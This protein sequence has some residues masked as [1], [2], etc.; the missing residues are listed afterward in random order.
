VQLNTAV[1]DLNT[2]IHTAVAAS[3]REILEKVGTQMEKL[4]RQT[5]AA[6]DS[7]AKVQQPNPPATA[8]R[9]PRPAAAPL[10][11]SDADTDSRHPA[12][13][14]TYTVQKGDTI[15][16]IARKTGAK[17]QDIITANKLTDPS[18]IMVG[19]TLLIPGGK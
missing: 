7:L 10:V 14:A 11:A 8:A 19:Q 4:A 3:K 2:A 5:N 13:A 9:S 15:E 1:A 6:L 18:R 16:Q 17:F 12:T